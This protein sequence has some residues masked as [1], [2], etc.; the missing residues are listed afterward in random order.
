MNLNTT[1]EIKTLK[2]ICLENI[3]ASINATDA[4]IQNMTYRR[5]RGGTYI[6]KIPVE[7][8]D[9]IKR[10]QNGVELKV[11]NW[12]NNEFTLLEMSNFSLTQPIAFILN[13]VCYRTG[14]LW[15]TVY[16]DDTEWNSKYPNAGPSWII[17][18]Q[19]KTLADYGYK[20]G[21]K[22]VVLVDRI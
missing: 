5:I 11:N 1:F 17:A 20:F 21:D 3:A 14:V 22:V 10:F 8:I 2:N 13:S 4:S 6:P 12:R 15:K 9:E 19:K 16:L 7:L 18:D